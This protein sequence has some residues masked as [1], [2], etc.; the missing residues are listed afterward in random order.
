MATKEEIDGCILDLTEELGLALEGANIR[1]GPDDKMIDM[2]LTIFSKIKDPRKPGMVTYSLENLLAI[3]VY[4]AIKDKI[5]SFNY[6]ANYVKVKPAVFKKLGLIDGKNY[7][8]HDTFERIFRIIDPKEMKTM[9]TSNLSRFW[10]RIED[11]ILPSEK[12][13]IMKMGSFDGQE[14][15]ATGRSDTSKKPSRNYNV[16]SLYSNTYAY[17]KG[18]EVVDSKTNEIPTAQSMLKRFDLTN[19]VLT[20]DALHCQYETAAIIVDKKGD[21]V[22]RVKSNQPAL[23]EKLIKLIDEAKEIERVSYGDRDYEILFLGDHVISPEWPGAV[24]AIR[25]VS[26]KRD[27]VDRNNPN[28]QPNTHYF[29]STL[30]RTEP[31]VRAI[32]RRWE[33]EDDL[34]MF[35]DVQ[36][37]QDKMRCHEVNI[38][39]NINILN[40]FIFSLYKIAGKLLGMKPSEVRIKYSDNPLVLI[41]FVCQYFV[42]RNLSQLFEDI[43]RRKSRTRK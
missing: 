16:L 21:Y 18:T 32:D 28:R 34:H 33:I 23:R 24:A 15:N 19:T 7:P 11:R 22:L 35:K 37:N 9:V 40:G 39:K 4:V 3:Y 14:M 38:A 6:V 41:G 17:A 2:A 43:N 8:S 31:I 26:H 27:K 20:S 12:K 1:C 36:L 29:I 10:A 42:G 5:P 30:K 25:M 13:Q